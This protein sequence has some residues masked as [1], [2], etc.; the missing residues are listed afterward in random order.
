MDYLS[1]GHVPEVGRPW[2]QRPERSPHCC[3]LYSPVSQRKKLKIQIYI[4]VT[5][6][7]YFLNYSKSTLFNTVLHIFYPSLISLLSLRS[8]KQLLLCFLLGIVG[9]IAKIVSRKYDFIYEF[10][11][12]ISIRKSFK[13]FKH[14]TL[15]Y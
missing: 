12:Y 7:F 14:L 5:S 11:F 13:L 10:Y 1:C 6:H 15:Q 9:Q 4:N 8:R 3:Q 2:Q